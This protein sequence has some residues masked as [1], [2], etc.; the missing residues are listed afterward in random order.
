MLD[1][2]A[3]LDPVPFE[4][5]HP[6][7]DA[8]IIDGM[9]GGRAALFLRAHHVLTDGYGGASILNLLLDESGRARPRP[10]SRPMMARTH[11]PMVAGR[12]R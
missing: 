3:L 1:V 2:V 8:T 5:D 4:P 11:R 9:A 7:W 10:H 12:V 6:P